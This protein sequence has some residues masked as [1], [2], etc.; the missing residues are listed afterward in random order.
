MISLDDEEFFVEE[1]PTVNY[2][3]ATRSLGR[4]QSAVRW[5]PDC[6]AGSGVVAAGTWDDAENTLALWAVQLEP[7]EEEMGGMYDAEDVLEPAAR[8]LSSVPH[9][10]CVL[11]LATAAA[12]P[13]APPLILT[14]GGDGALSC[15]SAS[16]SGVGGTGLTL[17]PAWS[18]AAGDGEALLGVG[19]SLDSRSVACCGEAGVLSVRDIE[20]GAERAR[21]SSDELCLFSVEWVVRRATQLGGGQ[22]INALPQLTHCFAWL[23]VRSRRTRC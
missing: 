2:V 13:A 22:Q 4:K 6:A 7:Q 1:E 15:F 17:H 12:G 14:A 11:G 18:Q 3:K 16:A 19:V 23:S 8:L 10:G 9:K 21:A 5:L 20:S